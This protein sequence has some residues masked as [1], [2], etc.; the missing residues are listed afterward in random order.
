MIPRLLR[1]AAWFR[2]PDPKT[3][4]NRKR[5]LERLCVECGVS[6]SKAVE[7]ASRFFRGVE[8]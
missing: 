3:Q 4:A 1:W 8:K 7:I 6:K 5:E 2:R